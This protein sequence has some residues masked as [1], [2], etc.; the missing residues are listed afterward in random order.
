[1]QFEIRV[2]DELEGWDLISLNSIETEEGL[3]D[4]V[5]ATFL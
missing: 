3:E 2:N 1:M 4:E 5:I